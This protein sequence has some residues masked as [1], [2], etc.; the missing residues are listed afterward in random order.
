MIFKFIS[1]T[2]TVDILAVVYLLFLILEGAFRKWF[3]PGLSD[4]FLLAR[5]PIAILTF[6]ICIKN[7]LIPKYILL[8]I[9]AF[10]LFEIVKA[11]LFGDNFFVM[12]YGIRTLFLHISII[13][14][15]GLLLSEKVLEICFDILLIS[16]PILL[17][18]VLFQTTSDPY[19]FINIGIG[20]VGT[21]SFASSGAGGG[22]IR[23]SGTFSFITGLAAYTSLVFSVS[24][25]RLFFTKKR[26]LLSVTSLFSCLIIVGVALSRT[27]YFSV[28]LVV[29]S[30]ILCCILFNIRINLFRWNK[31]LL[32]ILSLLTVFLFLFSSNPFILTK[33]ES[34]SGRWDASVSDR[35]GV[36]QT[37]LP[38]VLDGF[39]GS[40]GHVLIEPV[41]GVGVGKGTRVGA[42][43]SGFKNAKLNLG[44]SDADR[45]LNE[46]GVPRAYTYFIFRYYLAFSILFFVFKAKSPTSLLILFSVFPL[47]LIGQFAQPT[48]YGF[49]C[50]G[51]SLAMSTARYRV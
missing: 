11:L 42:V 4:L 43:L 48:I 44:E 30:L 1:K 17:A 49:A 38:R 34:F 13:F 24:L 19:S 41:L 37:I 20:G 35:G 16:S 18:I 5:D 31:T 47:L 21:S 3:L 39:F 25:S 46:V 7:R 10:S 12:I 33:L 50:F 29:F 14:C 23:P 9:L 6:I 2:S 51:A 8:Y 36:S 15:F 28:G 32:G 45:L 27:L 22:Q 26:F 40:S